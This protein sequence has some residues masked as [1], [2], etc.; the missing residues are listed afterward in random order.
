MFHQAFTY[1]PLVPSCRMSTWTSAV[2]WS[3]QGRLWSRTAAPATSRGARRKRPRI[4][5]RTSVERRR[6]PP[7][8]GTRSAAG[9]RRPARRR[10]P[11]PIVDGRWRLTIVTRSRPRQLQIARCRRRH[12][13]RFPCKPATPLRRHDTALRSW[14]RLSYRKWSAD[15]GAAA[16]ADGAGAMGNRKQ[17]RRR[18][19]AVGI[20][21]RTSSGV[22][23]GRNGNS[24][25]RWLVHDLDTRRRCL[26]GNDKAICRLMSTIESSHLNTSNEELNLSN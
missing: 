19:C 8:R 24:W 1:E 23:W 10:R 11:S 13:A 6:A 25:C 26:Q 2:Q 14:R 15:V 16:E 12:A 7:G 4:R 21:R 5:R 3:C 9:V 20:G 18:G 22:E 17:R